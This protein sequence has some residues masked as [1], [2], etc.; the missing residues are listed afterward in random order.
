MR[1]SQMT[2]GKLNIA[3]EGAANITRFIAS[4]ISIIILIVRISN[5][6]SAGVSDHIIVV[7]SFET[8]LIIVHFAITLGDCDRVMPM[9]KGENEMGSKSIC[10]KLMVIMLLIEFAIVG[11]SSY[12]LSQFEVVQ[13]YFRSSGKKTP[14][15]FDFDSAIYRLCAYCITIFIQFFAWIAS[16][17]ER[18]MYGHLPLEEIDSDTEL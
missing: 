9:I 2:C 11:L 7:V 12:E 15:Y 5:L 10:T 18:I 4:S 6:T 1:P 3:L 14:G 8:G 13:N 17:N 16:R